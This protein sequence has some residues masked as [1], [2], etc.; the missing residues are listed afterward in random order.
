MTIEFFLAAFFGALVQKT[1][2]A[3]DEVEHVFFGA[4]A[5][6]VLLTLLRLLF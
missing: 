5:L 4:L 2:S 6:I 1:I 3:E